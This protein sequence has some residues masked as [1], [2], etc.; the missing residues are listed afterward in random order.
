MKYTGSKEKLQK[1]ST[2]NKKVVRNARKKFEKK[3]AKDF[4]KNPKLFS[5]YISKIPNLK[6][7]KVLSIMVILIPK[8]IQ[9]YVKL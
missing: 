5:S 9:E 7:L 6:H 8:I 3:L 2:G 1:L 4:K